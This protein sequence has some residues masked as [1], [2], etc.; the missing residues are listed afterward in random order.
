MRFIECLKK[1]YAGLSNIG[2]NCSFQT[3]FVLIFSIDSQ[4]ILCNV[5]ITELFRKKLFSIIARVIDRREV[6]TRPEI[7]HKRNDFLQLD[8]NCVIMIR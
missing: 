5:R 1:S 2:N 6:K 4:K 8:E 7:N 3:I